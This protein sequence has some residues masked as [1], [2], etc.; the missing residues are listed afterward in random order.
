MS[1]KVFYDTSSLYVEGRE[2]YPPRTLTATIAG[3]RIQVATL[4]GMMIANLEFGEYATK[5][6]ATFTTAALAK[7]YLD[8][9]FAKYP[10][11]P[12]TLVGTTTITET[13]G[14]AVSLG[15]RRY[16]VAMPGAAVGDRLVVALTGAPT[17]GTIQDVYVSAVNTVNIGILVPA[18][19]LN[20]QISVPIAV[21]RVS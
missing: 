10:P 4:S 14:L 16:S 3:T 8:G 21:Y 11:A 13:L 19:A 5:T 2:P 7:A 12:L 18:L 15:V 20:A 6:G 17:N 9:E 1:T